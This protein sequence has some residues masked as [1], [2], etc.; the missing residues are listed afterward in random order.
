MGTISVPY[1]TL[2]LL[3]GNGADGST[4]LT[5]DNGRAVTV[6]GDARVSTDRAMFDQTSSLRFD[7]MGDYMAVPYSADMTLDGDLTIEA[8]VNLAALPANG[9]YFCIAS[10]SWD[11]PV[12]NKGWFL[13]INKD[14]TL[15]L[16]VHFVAYA[17]ANSVTA[18]LFTLWPTGAVDQWV[19]VA[20]VKCNQ[21]V[22]VFLN[23]V[24]GTW[25]ALPKL[26]QTLAP[27]HIGVGNPSGA[28]PWFMNGYISELRIVSGAALYFDTFTPPV[29][30]LSAVSGTREL[31]GALLSQDWIGMLDLS[32][33]A[34]FL[35]GPKAV[36]AAPVL[37]VGN[38]F[39]AGPGRVAGT[40]KNTPATPVHR[41]VHLLREPTLELVRSQWSDPV[42]GAYSFDGVD[43][44][45]TYTVLSFDHTQAFRAVV[46]DRVVP[47][48]M[49]ET[50]P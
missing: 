34:Q 38:R 46:A 9:Q 41:K 23:G 33:P 14:T 39:Y 29:A 49:L 21:G 48:V 31:V 2:L 13:G 24:P 30:P 17:E 20:A 40:V 36:N 4:T 42:T 16:R 35:N 11:L 6:E 45:C 47:E 25:A 27:I 10:Q 18:N 1:T 12:P 43:T 5:D 26:N 32:D 22:N 3:R 28:T 7:G 15:G 44:T 19:H 50:V 37:R 8:W